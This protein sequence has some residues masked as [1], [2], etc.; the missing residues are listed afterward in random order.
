VTVT[1]VGSPIPIELRPLAGVG[2]ASA[3][4]A[5][6]VL[7]WKQRS[8]LVAGL[9]VAGGIVSVIYGVIITEY[10]RI[11]VFPGPIV[12]FLT[13]TIILGLGIAKS[14]MMRT[15]IWSKTAAARSSYI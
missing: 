8:N 2:V 10:L 14:M 6:F 11:L 12:A 15:T 13:G 7:S 4:T 5:A 3:S 9:L 1:T